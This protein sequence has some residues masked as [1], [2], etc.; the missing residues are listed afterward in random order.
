ME[1]ILASIRRIIADDEAKPA[2]AQKP[3]APPPAPEKPAAAPAAKP[4]IKPVMKDI[5]RWSALV[6]PPLLDLM[7]GKCRSVDRSG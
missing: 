7:P 4:V 3:S 1:E 6:R 2:A 5:P